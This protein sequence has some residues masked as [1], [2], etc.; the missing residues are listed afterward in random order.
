[1]GACGMKKRY[2]IASSK[3]WDR[4]M[5]NNLSSSVEGEFILITEK[6]RLT[7]NYLKEKKPCFIFFPHWSYIIPEEIYKNFKCVIFHMTDVPFGRGG[8][9]LQ[10][11]IERGIY[12]TKISA[13]KAVR[14]LDA[15]D[16]YLKEDLSLQ[17]SAGEIYIRATEIIKSMIITIIKNKPDP[18]PQYG[19]VVEFQRRKPE[20]SNIADLGSLEKVFDHIR[21]LDAE[22]YPHAFIETE[23]I[24]F[25]FTGAAL[26]ED[27]VLANVKI[28]KKD[29]S[30]K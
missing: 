15:G 14:E 7:C 4:D 13:L 18:V 1:M 10:N 29:K 12:Q 9:P 2:V 17:G 24:R 19:E 22:G 25:E 20:Q 11:L 28:T 3:I 30:G 8:S 21:M 16:V 27:A 6:D 23:H 26:K 5:I